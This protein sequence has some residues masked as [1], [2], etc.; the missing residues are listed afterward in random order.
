MTRHRTLLSSRTRPV[1]RSFCLNAILLKSARLCG[2]SSHFCGNAI[3]NRPRRRRHR[4]NPTRCEQLGK[5]AGKPF[6]HAL[7]CL[8]VPHPGY[9]WAFAGLARARRTAR[10]EARRPSRC[11]SRDDITRRASQSYSTRKYCRCLLY[12][13]AVPSLFVGTSPS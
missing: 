13:N 4:R 10:F 12:Y 11:R 3:A 2:S 5:F 1:S 7:C 8:V 6:S 9:L